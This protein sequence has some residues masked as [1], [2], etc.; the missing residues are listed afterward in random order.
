MKKSIFLAAA[1]L[2]CAL[3][4]RAQDLSV[5]TNVL[6][7][8]NFGT[9]NA[10]ASYGFARHWSVSAA[11]KYNPFSFDEGV[12][13]KFNRQQLFAAGLRFWPWHIFSGWWMG[14]KLQYQE[15]NT[16]GITSPETREGDRYGGGLSGGYTY[17]LTPWLNVDVGLGV[18]AGYERSTSFA[19]Q[20]CG[21]MVG[22]GEKFFIHPNDI[23][24][25]LS[26][27]F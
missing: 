4:A 24:V 23:L 2:V 20:R 15:F 17:M 1:A 5:S 25:S 12:K 21:R 14:G 8:A 18:W 19:C 22:Q 6:D 16:G 11:L 13:E 3:C 9:L 27:I 7:F 26:I 10:E